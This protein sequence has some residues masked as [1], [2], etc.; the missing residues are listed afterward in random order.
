MQSHKREIMAHALQAGL[1]ERVASGTLSTSAFCHPLTVN[2]ALQCLQIPLYTPASLPEPDARC[3]SDRHIT[4]GGTR[5][6]CVCKAA[7][8]SGQSGSSYKCG[9]HKGGHRAGQGMHQSPRFPRHM[10][11]VCVVH[12]CGG[13]Q[14]TVLDGLH[15]DSQIS[16]TN[17][18][19]HKGITRVLVASVGQEWIAKA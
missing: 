7:R 12:R 9:G 13:F 8:S 2:L 3:Q 1:T 4:W 19:A 5:D 11:L 16:T 6:P 17:F 14:N 10:Q 18:G 15:S